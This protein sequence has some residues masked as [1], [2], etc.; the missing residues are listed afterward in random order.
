MSQ[1]K[2]LSRHKLSFCQLRLLQQVYSSK[3][4][5]VRASHNAADTEGRQ[6][7]Q[8]GRQLGQKL[9]EDRHR[10]VPHIP[11]M[12]KEV[13]D[14]LKPTDG[15]VIVDMTFGGGGHTRE[16]ISRAQNARVFALDR[17][18]VAFEMATQLSQEC[19]EGQIT[20]LLGR[21]SDVPQLLRQHGVEGASV[22]SFLFDVGASS[23]QFDQA[24]RGFSLSQDGPLDMRMDGDRIQDQP[25]AADVVNHIDEQDLYVI[26]KK[27]GEEKLARKIASAIVDTRYAFGNITRT[28]QLADIVASVFQGDLRRDKMMRHSHVATKTFQALRIFVNDELNELNNGLELA[29]RF[30]KP[31]GVCVALSFHSLE[32]RIVKRHFHGID[33]DLPLNMNYRDHLRNPS[34]LHERKDVVDLLKKRWLPSSKKVCVPTYTDCLDNPRARSAKLRAA[35]KIQCN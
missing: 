21:F 5:P 30:L 2:Q 17:D 22:D 8:Q 9:N 31:G 13:M 28:R 7:D 11:V 33:M 4:Q 18:P 10:R 26:I 23:M 6:L 12:L 14:V 15:Q 35:A 29:H 27:Y 32:D 19:K 24:G 3:C 34:V 16:I 25:T 1:V 20:P